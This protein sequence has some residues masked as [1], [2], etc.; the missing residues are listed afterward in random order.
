MKKYL[1]LAVPLSFAFTQCVFA[2]TANCNFHPKISFD[3]STSSITSFPYNQTI[4]NST[5]VKITPTP[6][7][8]IAAARTNFQINSSN[9]DLTGTSP[10]GVKPT[11]NIT[12]L[13]GNAATMDAAR[14]W[15]A[16]NLKVSFNL[17]DVGL[18][19]DITNQ[20][21]SYNILPTTSST[22]STTT[23]NG[24]SFATGL[25][26]TGVRD[27]N[28]IMPNVKIQL[29]NV[30]KPSQDI[31]D[32][33][34]GKQIEMHVGT[35][36]VEYDNWRRPT[37]VTET[38]SFEVYMNVTLNFG[39]FP[40]CTMA[41]QTVNLATVPT[42]VL[43]SSQTANEQ[44][45]DVTLNCSAA[46]PSSVLV[47]TLM[48]SFSPSNVNSN[49]ILKNQPTLA[50]RS[51]VDVQLRDESNIPL[52][53]GSQK[54]FYSVP[55][56]STATQFSKKLKAQYFRSAPT[57]TSGYVHANTTVFLDYE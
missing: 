33:L 44:S 7:S 23:I 37:G 54:S 46:I 51:N 55:A 10:F 43:N 1:W 5:K 8:P 11:V 14:N 13:T 24:E 17:L 27:I 45:F 9:T 22:Q 52:E 3:R 30:G 31:I 21:T 16:S 35:M 4:D 48:D 57:A 19:I 50:N 25:N 53:I 56:G 26:G 12:G 29:L 28:V 47:A 49:G 36:S 38:K 42:S 39:G 41:D 15:L 18:T 32:A 2:T 34:N 20:D 40:T 6:C